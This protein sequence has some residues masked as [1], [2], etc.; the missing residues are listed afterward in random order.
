MIYFDS[1][2]NE[3]TFR[4]DHNKPQISW[5]KTI[6]FRRFRIRENM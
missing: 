2:E 4:T 6:R 1:F 3:N 5:E